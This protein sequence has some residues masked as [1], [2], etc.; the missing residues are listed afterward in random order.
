[1]APLVCQLVA[2]IMKWGDWKCDREQIKKRTGGK[3]RTE[4]EIM[5]AVGLLCVATYCFTAARSTPDYLLCNTSCTSGFVDDVRTAHIYSTGLAYSVERIIN[6][7]RNGTH[8]KFDSAVHLCI[9]GNSIRLIL[10]STTVCR[11]TTVQRNLISASPHR[12]TPTFA[13]NRIYV[14][15]LLVAANAFVS[16]GRWAPIQKH[17]TT[18]RFVSCSFKSAPVSQMASWSVQPFLRSSTFSHTDHAVRDKRVAMAASTHRAQTMRPVNNEGLPPLS[19][20]QR[21]FTTLRR[22]YSSSCTL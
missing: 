20:V 7:S 21:C 8:V 11:L 18:D 6:R 5:L 15:S 22:D 10:N 2:S 9:V 4:N 16:R 1:M 13:V 19:G 14:S 3:C 12:W 17:D